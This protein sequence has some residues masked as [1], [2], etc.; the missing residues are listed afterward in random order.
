MNPWLILKTEKTADPEIVKRA[1]MQL[2][3]KHNPE[4]DPEGFQTIRAAYEQALAEIK[5]LE[6]PKDTTPVGI[7]MDKFSKMYADFARR[8][9]PQQWEELLEDEVCI[10][11][12]T[13]DQVRMRVLE[14]IMEHHYFPRTVW[15]LLNRRFL[16]AEQEEELKKVFPPEFI[17]YVLTNVNSQWGIHYHLFDV[18]KDQPFDR[19]IYLV[20]EINY[21]LNWQLTDDLDELVQ[22]IRDLDIKHPSYMIIEG[23][24]LALEGQSK[25]ALKRINYVFDHYRDD[26]ENDWNANFA[27]GAILAASKERY[28]IEQAITVYKSML[29]QIPDD[30]LPKIQLLESLL[31]LEKLEEAYDFI[32]NDILV[33]FP[34]DGNA[35]A[36]LIEVSNL[37]AQKYE[38]IY[39]ENSENPETVLNLV[40]YYSNA[41]RQEEA[42]KILNQHSEMLDHDKYN[43]YMANSLY[44]RKDFAKAVEHALTAIKINPNER[45]YYAVLIEA[46]AAQKQ[47]DEALAKAKEA[48]AL[49]VKDGKDAIDKANIYNSMAAVFSKLKKYED[50]LA[51]CRQGLELHDR[52]FSL[53][54]TQAEVFKEMGDFLEAVECAE[55]SIALVPMYPIPYEIQAEIYYL[56]GSYEQV[57]EIIERVK[58]FEMKSLALSFY[59]ASALR[60]LKKYEQALAM[61][62]ELSQQEDTGEY[63]EKIMVELAYTYYHLN[64]SQKA[65][66]HMHQAIEAAK[67]KNEEVD[68]YWYDSLVEIYTG[69]HQYKKAIKICNDLIKKYPDTSSFLISRGRVYFEMGKPA[70]AL[71][72]FKAA[73]AIDEHNELIFEWLIYLHMN[74]GDTQKAIW[75]AKE[76]IDTCQTPTAHTG[77]AAIYSQSKEHDLA[78]ST[79]HKALVIFPNNEEILSSLGHLYGDDL[80]EHEQAAA[81]W[82]RLLEINPENAIAYDRLA[83]L[84]GFLKQEEQALNLLNAGLEKIPHHPNLYV[85]RAFIL[86]DL[87]RDEAA[88]KDLFCAVENLELHE[89]WYSEIELYEY[90]VWITLG[91]LDIEQSLKYIDKILVRSPMNK[92]ALEYLA[93]IH[94]FYERDYQQAVNAYSKVLRLDPAYFWAYVYRGRAYQQLGQFKLA[95]KDYQQVTKLLIDDKVTS[96][97]DYVAKSQAYLHLR[98]FEK[99]LDYLEKASALA[100]T[101]GTSIDGTCQCIFRGYAQY[102]LE[103]G[104]L[105]EAAA[106]IEKAINVRDGIIN[107]AVKQDILEKME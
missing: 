12:D 34:Y 49:P 40:K 55:K 24:L 19:F 17:D 51:A 79:L 100:K 53:Y 13:E 57:L 97:D 87:K 99:A 93:D 90:I 67:S 36:R 84:L 104:N 23:R 66:T 80:N 25:A 64:E 74:Q 30:Y 95:K 86:R 106:S 52:L 103:Q 35:Y 77:L 27:Y 69:L 28:Q 6:S 4:D 11:L 88:L 3:S 50:A 62:T 92:T 65:L 58:V 32:A 76:Q 85:R 82:S 89:T 20:N 54:A 42:D 107:Q 21:R 43:A 105:E 94:L 98:K 78:L 14:F 68:L 75:W 72:D 38:A 56:M 45:W 41:Y 91:M 1:Y 44:L 31:Q 63:Q 16:W 47:Y 22:E 29:K 10:A 102:Y 18:T 2:I 46:L 39:E 83:W 73:L 8:I 60:A 5:E 59:H 70:K 61:L 71:Q 48:L 81:T 96:H 101:D 33:A 26:Y 15:Q 37:L 7:F 9:D